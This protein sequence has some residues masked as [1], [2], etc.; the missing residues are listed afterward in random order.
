MMMLKKFR[1]LAL[2]MALILVVVSCTTFAANKPLKLIYGNLYE[3]GTLFHDKGDLYFKKL[4]EKNSKGRIL[5]DLYSSGQLG[6]TPEQYQAIKNGVQHMT[7]SPVGDFVQ[8]CPELATFDL[9]Y[10]YR[11]E[12]HF[13]KV[14]ERFTSLIDQNKIAK[15]GY[16]I[17]G[18]WFRTPRQLTTKFP[19][20]KLEDIKGLKIRVSASPVSLALWK[21]LGT[22]PIVTPGSEIYTALATGVADAQENPLENIY[23]GKFYEVTNYC[24]L[25]AHKREIVVMVASNKFWKGLTKWQRK[26]IQ[27]ALNETTK[28]LR[29]LVL[30]DEEKFKDLL[31]KAGMKFTQPDT[32]SFGERAKTIWGQFGDKNLIKKIQ[33]LK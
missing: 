29:K 11:D 25:T 19:V 23:K 24:A 33:A 2:V 17:V 14:A 18:T 15:K 3:P 26:I 32:V 20:N 5:V 6:T 22:I 4:V 31:T 8:F 16:R 28:R 12:K 21:A 7:F 27:N 9:P 13:L 10:V 1:C 30:E